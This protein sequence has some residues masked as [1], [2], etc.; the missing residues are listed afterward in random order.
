MS[1][2]RRQ[3]VVGV[4][5]GTVGIAGM[6]S[7]ALAQGRQPKATVAFQ[8]TPRRGEKCGTCKLFR[9]A[10]TNAN[11]AKCIVVEGDVTARSWCVLWEARSD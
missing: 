3:V 5:A 8:N 11:S 9:P 4:I 1:T 10:E 7:G 2:T 6:A